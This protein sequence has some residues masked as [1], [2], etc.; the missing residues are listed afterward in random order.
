M[1]DRQIV[2]LP[3]RRR[4]VKPGFNRRMNHQSVPLVKMANPL[5]HAIGVRDKQIHVLIHGKV[6]RAEPLKKQP[7]QPAYEPGITVKINTFKSPEIPRGRMT[8]TNVNGSRRL[9]DPFCHTV[10]TRNNDIRRINFQGA[11]RERQDREEPPVIA[12]NTRKI[13]KE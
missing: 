5:L 9:A 1:R 3:D 4:G 13:L 11:D 10:R 12:P 7:D 6:P 8:I 2:I